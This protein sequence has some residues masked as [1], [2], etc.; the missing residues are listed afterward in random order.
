LETLSNTMPPKRAAAGSQAV[1]L[2][3][4]SSHNDVLTFMSGLLTVEQFDKVRN[5]WEQRL[6]PAE[7]H[8]P[9]P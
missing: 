2:N 3:E 7:R 4:N 9:S 1:F 8:L 6:G 5:A